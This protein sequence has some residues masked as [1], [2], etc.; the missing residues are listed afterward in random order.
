MTQ[1][2]PY[3]GLAGDPATHF[4]FPSS[5]QRCHATTRPSEISVA[6]QARD[7][8]TAQHPDCDRYRPP[9]PAP[10]ASAL[11]AAVAATSADVATERVRTNR[12]SGA[13]RPAH[14]PRTERRLARVTVVVLLAVGASV[15]GLL[16]GSWLGGQP[17]SPLAS[18]RAGSAS[19][20]APSGT[21]LASPSGAAASADPDA[22]PSTPSGATSP[23]VRPATSA[24]PTE[25]V[26]VKGESLTLIAERY[27]VTVAALQK[28]NNIVDPNK[29]VVGQKLVIPTP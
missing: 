24:R 5:V 21:G 25:H 18:S 11:A 15:G 8:L 13:A 12:D 26:V 9:S 4:A 17:G 22:I 29:I 28:A 1:V 27:G 3:L 14:G 2:C 20:A 7:C 10:R 6:K 16:I 19:Q 23:T